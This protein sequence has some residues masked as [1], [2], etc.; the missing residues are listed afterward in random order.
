MNLQ[1]KKNELQAG[2]E[3][4]ANILIKLSL[5]QIISLL[6]KLKINTYLSYLLSYNTNMKNINNFVRMLLYE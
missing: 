6:F 1:C 4:V 2:N 3:L 5:L